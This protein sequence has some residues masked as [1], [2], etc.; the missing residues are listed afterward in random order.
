LK[1]SWEKLIAQARK[2]KIRSAYLLYGEEDFRIDRALGELVDALVPE[3]DRALNLVT[4][5]GA[6]VAWE[7]VLDHL[8]TTS[9]FGGRKVV[10][11]EGARLGS[12]HKEAFMKAKIAW[13]DGSEGKQRRSAAIMMGILGD[14]DW[15]IEAL[16]DGGPEA[17][18]AEE[19]KNTA[20]I[21][22]DEKDFEWM[23]QLLDYAREQGLSPRKADEGAKLQEFIRTDPSTAVLVLTAKSANTRSAFYKSIAAVGATISFDAPKGDYRRRASLKSEIDHML[24]KAG[25]KIDSEAMRRLE[26]KTGFDLR[27]ATGEIEKLLIFVGDAKYIRAE[28]VE[29]VVPRTKEESVFQLNDALMRRNAAESL[30]LIDELTGAGHH[31]LELLAIIHNQIRNLFLATRYAG[32]LP[33]SLW[34]PRM[35]YGDFQKRAWPEITK[36]KEKNGENKKKRVGKKTKK[37]HIAELENAPGAAFPKLHPFVAYNAMKNQA[38]FKPKELMRAF[39]LLAVVDERAKRSAGDPTFL[40]EQAVLAICK[41]QSTFLDKRP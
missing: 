4:L 16:S 33:E 13:R 22:V 40:L 27:R 18:S 9:M 12:S 8:R 11:V 21:E 6:E 24:A 31:P 2:G 15:P 25:K 14:L 41:N 5:D 1:E 26:L 39:R 20:K 38:N 23:T 3:Q 17:R 36:A 28:D 19:W 30:R 32:E 7:E 35:N 37:D 10:V 29:A 34:N